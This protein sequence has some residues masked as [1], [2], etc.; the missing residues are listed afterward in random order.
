MAELLV[1]VDGAQVPLKSCEWVFYA[2]CGCPVG[3]CWPVIGDTVLATE[4]AVFREMYGSKRE[5]AKARKA[6]KTARLVS[7][8]DFLEDVVPALTGKCPHVAEAVS[9]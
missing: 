8:E 9:A 3:C 2:A 4:D 1:E 5:A 7:R 6:G